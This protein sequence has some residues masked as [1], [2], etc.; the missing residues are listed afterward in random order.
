MRT[1]RYALTGH[2]LAAAVAVLASGCK[3]ST[4]VTPPAVINTAPIIDSLTMASARAEAD[5]PIQ[6]TAV[7]RDAEST[8]DKLTYTWSASP[9]AGSF[10]GTMS[11]IGNQVINTWWPP[12]GETTPD[13]YTITLTV[14]EAYTSAGQAK[15]NVVP[16]S[17]TVHY[18]DSLKEMTDLA[19]DFLVYKFGNFNVSPAEAVSNFSNSC[20]GKAAEMHQIEN[21]RRDYHILSASFP[22]PVA[23]TNSSL[24]TGKV[25]GPCTFEDIPG[26]GQDNEGRREFVH[27]TCLLTTVYESETFRWR[28]C[29]SFFNGPHYTELASIRNRV[30]GRPYVR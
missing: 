13:V 3:G 16:S 21:N 22:A 23:S 8:I 7:V 28:L 9:Q 26:P 29:D 17:T 24:T 30:P 19:Y 27:G 14:S 12:K 2:T 5:R 20:P 10:G 4:P 18:N 11:F 25:E 15:Q 1:H 6:V